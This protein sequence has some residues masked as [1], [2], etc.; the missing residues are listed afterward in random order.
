MYNMMLQDSG[1]TLGSNTVVGD[2][3]RDLQDI[4]HLHNTCA[5]ECMRSHLHDALEFIAD[6]HTLTK[7]KVKYSSFIM[8]QHCRSL[9]QIIFFCNAS[10][11]CRPLLNILFVPSW[12][13]CQILPKWL[14]ISMPTE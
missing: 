2:L 9:N 13:L 3:P 7:V 10:F 8:V 4:H 1:G 14:K 6:V 12:T 5:A 11:K